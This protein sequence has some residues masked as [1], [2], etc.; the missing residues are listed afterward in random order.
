[1]F[2]RCSYDDWYKDGGRRAGRSTWSDAATG[3]FRSANLWERWKV[4]K[5][6]KY[7]QVRSIESY[8]AEAPRDCNMVTVENAQV[9]PNRPSGHLRDDKG[10]VFFTI[11]GERTS[12]AIVVQ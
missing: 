5:V 11:A 12:N 9:V 3:R 6:G 2:L 1:M 7:P 10:Q 4:T 8:T